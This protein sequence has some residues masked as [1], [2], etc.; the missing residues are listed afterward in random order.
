MCFCTHC[1]FKS[2]SLLRSLLFKLSSL[3]CILFSESLLLNSMFFSSLGL[4][5]FI[6]FLC[7]SCFSL[8]FSLGSF[9]VSFGC[10]DVRLLHT[11]SWCGRSFLFLHLF[12][13]FQ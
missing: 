9:L 2:F 4:G 6:S 3:L 12:F 5:F 8:P 13:S 7:R 11:S 10:F 1:P